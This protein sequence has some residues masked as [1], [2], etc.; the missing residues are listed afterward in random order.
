MAPRLLSFVAALTLPLACQVLVGIEERKEYRAPATGGAEN[1]GAAGSPSEEPSGGSSS[2]GKGNGGS[3]PAGPEVCGD[4]IQQGA[5]VCDDGDENGEAGK[6]H[7]SCSFVCVGNCPLHVD[8]QIG[9]A[10]NGSSWAIA[11][12]SLQDA[13]DQQWMA[14]GG[15]VWVKATELRATG[16]GPLLVLR[17]GVDV[18]GGFEGTEVRR[19]DRREPTAASATVLHA[20]ELAAPAVMG[21]SSARLDG[22][23]IRDAVGDMGA[24]FQ[25]E[26]TTGLIL[27]DVY[28]TENHAAA[29]GGAM[30]LENASVRLEGGAFEGNTSDA[31][32]GAI[33]ARKAS[34]LDMRGTRFMGN[35]AVTSG[36]AIHARGDYSPVA[37]PTLVL[38]DTTF[39][40][41]GATSEVSNEGGGALEQVGGTLTVSDSDFQGNYVHALA[42]GAALRL[43][44]VAGQ[45]VNSLFVEHV[46]GRPAVHST[47]GSLSIVG[48][49]FAFNDCPDGCDVGGD[50]IVLR[51]S[52]LVARDKLMSPT[53]GQ[54]N[55]ADNCHVF[56]SGGLGE[57]PSPF[58]DALLDR[59]GNGV[60]D[61]LLVQ[62]G[63]NPCVDAGSDAAADDA[64]ID[65]RNMTTSGSGCL[66]VSPVDAGR[67]YP[68]S[69]A[70]AQGCQ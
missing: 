48:S 47:V 45:I 8:S 52:V 36:G 23:V 17:A 26:G 70:N 19:A 28:F 18:Y 33:C 14:G 31:T 37:H 20:N 13:V 10:G 66:D 9:R 27:R 22:F 25:A 11:L 42:P 65:W 56:L 6:C 50:S 67:H 3:G 49:T 63:D 24:A 60:D 12:R 7:E 16:P 69:N 64:G 62:P 55:A 51:N 39:I 21:A 61:Y 29:C 30:Y 40:D 38:K 34:S 44:D 1:G 59:D 32:G 43:E 41:N 2:G 15:E 57:R 46:E 5:E 54:V 53:S 58:G 4:G 35:R 68:S